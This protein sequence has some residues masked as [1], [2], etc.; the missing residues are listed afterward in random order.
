MVQPFRD[1]FPG[2]G[3]DVTLALNL[4]ANKY[5]NVCDGSVTVKS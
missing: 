2:S 4:P 1:N 3:I 5:H